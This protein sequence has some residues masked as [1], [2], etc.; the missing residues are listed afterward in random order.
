MAV[1]LSLTRGFRQARRHPTEVDAE[2]QY[3]TEAD[4][5]TLFQISTFGSDHRQSSPKVSQ[6]LQ[7]DLASATALCAAVRE[8]FPDA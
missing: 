3:I 2:Y 4:G 5:K 8:A 7:F 6:T 1:V